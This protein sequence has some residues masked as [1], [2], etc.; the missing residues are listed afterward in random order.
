MAVL[1]FYGMFDFAPGDDDTYR[2]SSEEFAELIAGVTGNGVSQNTLECFRTTASGLQL[3]VR[4]GICFING[5]YGVNRTSKTVYLTGTSGSIKR[6]DYL[7]LELDCAQRKI[8]LKAVQGVSGADP[9]PPPLTTNDVI[10]QIPLYLC[11]VSG[12]AA[13]LTDE[14]NLTFSASQIQG[15][16]N[17]KAPLDHTH[18]DIYYRRAD[19]DEALA[20]KAPAV[21]KATP[22]GTTLAVQD[23][24]EYYLTNVRNLTVTYPAGQ[25][26]CWLK[27]QTATE[28]T[29]T[30][31]I[32]ASQYLGGTPDLSQNGTT[33]ELSIKDGIIVGCEAGDGS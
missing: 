15:E 21:T 22:T 23:N 7:V 6:Y 14:R 32:P 26:E 16:L 4:S 33:F 17:G 27:I 31:A 2:Y 19:L 29:V 20:G 12:S 24:R 1:D 13:T 3:T 30:I 25:F 18:D 9:S 8:N 28:G 11:L 10:Y 5:R